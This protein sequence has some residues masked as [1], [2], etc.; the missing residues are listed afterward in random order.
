MVSCS[1]GVLVISRKAK[2]S[3]G[4]GMSATATVGVGSLAQPA[5]AK[6]SAARTPIL[7][8][9]PNDMTLSQPPLR[10]VSSRIRRQRPWIAAVRS[11]EGDGGNLAAVIGFAA[12]GGP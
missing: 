4:G 1:D 12:M 3:L 8:L 2:V 9:R 11:G 5:S 7:T 6:P 10:S